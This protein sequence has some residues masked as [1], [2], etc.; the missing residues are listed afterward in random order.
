MFWLLSVMILDMVDEAVM[1]VKVIYVLSVYSN[2]MTVSYLKT[3]I[4]FQ[5]IF[6]REESVFSKVLVV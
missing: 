5:M 6:R 4:C 2:T 1:N 3:V